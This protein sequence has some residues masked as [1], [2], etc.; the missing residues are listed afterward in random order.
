MAV[1]NKFHNSKIYTIRSPQTDKYYIGSTTQI[2]CKRLTNH[3]TDYDRYL[4]GIYHNIRSFKIIELGD[5]YIELL[6][7]FKC[8]NKEQL[9]KREGEIIRE[10]K[11]NCVNR[12]ISGRTAQEYRSDNKDKI[13]EQITQYRSDNKE[14]IMQYKSDNK[15][16][17]SE[18]QKQYRI[19][20]KERDKQY[21]EARKDKINESFTC[22][23]GSISSRRSKNRHNKTKKHIAFINTIIV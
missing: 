5:A 12:T 7:E 20:N 4:K 17:I 15:G 10:H 22:E 11:N 19:A 18:Q 21:R 16:K 2:L 9:E 6:E 23:C 8:E 13:Q 3:K 1:I 14:H